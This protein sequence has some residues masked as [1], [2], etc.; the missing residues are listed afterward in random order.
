MAFLAFESLQVLSAPALLAA[1][2]AA[3][4]LQGLRAERLEVTSPAGLLEQH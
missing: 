1:W 2:G 4:R 3:T